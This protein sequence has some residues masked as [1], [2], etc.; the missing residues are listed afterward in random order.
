MSMRVH[1]TATLKMHF[2][3]C[4]TY[5]NEIGTLPNLKPNK[6]A[7]LSTHTA[8]WK[9]ESGAIDSPTLSG[10][11]CN[12]CVCSLTPSVCLGPRALERHPPPGGPWALLRLPATTLTL[13]PALCRKAE[14]SHTTIWRRAVGRAGS[15]CKLTAA[16]ATPPGGLHSQIEAVLLSVLA[17]LGSVQQ[18]GVH[19]GD[20]DNPPREEGPHA[21]A[22]R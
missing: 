13:A 12:V 21:H 15:K 20:Q 16:S 10:C 11:L 18:A 5:K 19:Q 3:K 9:G 22:L 17:D 7:S 14:A 4:H 2:G 6:Q 8:T 1:G